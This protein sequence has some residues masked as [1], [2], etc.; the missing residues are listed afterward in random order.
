M[1]AASSGALARKPLPQKSSKREE[2]WRSH[3]R[4][5]PRRTLALR[6]RDTQTREGLRGNSSFLPRVRVQHGQQG[7]LQARPA[8]ASRVSAGHPA[9]PHVSAERPDLS[10]TIFASCVLWV[11]TTLRR[12]LPSATALSWLNPNYRVRVCPPTPR[13]KQPEAP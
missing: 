12:T 6:R 10:G 7:Q 1:K 5:A 11:P 13:H 4:R 3:P 2:Q 8:A 9:D